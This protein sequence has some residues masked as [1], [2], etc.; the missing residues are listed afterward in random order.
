MQKKA[1][2]TAV[3]VHHQEREEHAWVPHGRELGVKK[4]G[5]K[6]GVPVGGRRRQEEACQN[7]SSARRQRE[8]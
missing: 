2:N 7:I 5:K 8:S 6:L 3:Q 4:S 1:E